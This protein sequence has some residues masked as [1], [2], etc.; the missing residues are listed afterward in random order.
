MNSKPSSSDGVASHLSWIDTWANALTVPKVAS[1]EAIANE[2]PANPSRAYAW[3]VYSSLVAYLI[4]G[5][6]QLLFS[7]TVSQGELAHNLILQANPGTTLTLALCGAPI[8]AVGAVLG[9]IIDAAVIQ[10]FARR[11]GG[12]GSFRQ[13]VYVTAAI[14][15][16]L[17]I[18]AAALGAIPYVAY[19]NIPI[20]LYALYLTLVAVKAVNR[21]GWRKASLAG[22]IF[23]G[24]LALLAGLL[25]V[26]LFYAAGNLIVDLIR[27]FAK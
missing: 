11:L 21:F 8:V 18:I 10:L 2:A 12:E 1:F 26:L 9:V 16:P 3:V 4:N 14:V 23:P 27:G 7:G 20:G 13:M 22:L 25:L 5:A 17:T 15:S 6:I 24:A 19:L